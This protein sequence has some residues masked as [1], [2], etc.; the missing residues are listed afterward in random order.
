MTTPIAGLISQTSATPSAPLNAIQAL[1]T[2]GYINN[3]FSAT[4][5]LYVDPTGPAIIGSGTAMALAPGQ[6]FYIIPNSTLPVSVAS[7]VANHP[8]IAVQWI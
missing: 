1:L 7:T 2:G 4:I 5:P 6:T 8:F 3:P